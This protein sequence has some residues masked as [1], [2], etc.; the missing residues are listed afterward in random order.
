MLSPESAQAVKNVRTIIQSFPDHGVV[1]VFKK[2]PAKDVVISIMALAKLQRV[3]AHYDELQDETKSMD[4][5][6]SN[7]LL[8]ELAH[9]AVYANA[10]YGWK[11]D[12]AFKGK[13]RRNDLQTLLQSTGIQEEDV[14]AAEWSA[15]TLRPAYF[16]LKDR[17]M[18]TIVLCVRGTLSTRD[19]LTDL[20]C[21]AESFGTHNDRAHQ[22]MLHS[23]RFVSEAAK[24][25][26]QKQME[27]NPG[28]TLV[29]VG[30]SLGSGVAAILGT[31]WKA[32]FPDL[33][34][35]GYGSP[36]V[37]PVGCNPVDDSGNIISVVGEGDPFACLSLGHVADTSNIIAQFCEN[38]ELRRMVMMRTDEQPE[39]LDKKDLDWCYQTFMRLKEKLTGEKLFP[40]G[41]ILYMKREAANKLPSLS[42]LPTSRFSD[43]RLHPRMLDV[44]RHVPSVYESLLQEMWVKEHPNEE[45]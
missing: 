38:E 34:V 8:H 30:H 9:Y 27:E 45:L 7:D 24:E 41:R 11:L 2:Y 43:L 36:C 18:K 35:Y 23:A 16:V 32:D 22:G 42:E 5:T 3:A 39:D 44:S 6:I 29:L 19:V 14:I 31:I 15:K 21:T 28:Y 25:I 33:K 26:V 1:D 17:R 20:C 40:P 12:L 37:G 13:F 10:A 4:N